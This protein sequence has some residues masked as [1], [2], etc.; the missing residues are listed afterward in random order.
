MGSAQTH[1]EAGAAAL[2][3]GDLAAAQTAFEATVERDSAH[4]EGWHQLGLVHFRAHRLEEAVYGIERSLAEGAADARVH[5]NLGTVLQHLGRLDEAL[6]RYSEALE[7]DPDH[8]SA[9]SNLAAILTSRFAHEEA[10]AHLR[11]VLRL[12]PNHG[13]AWNNLGVLCRDTLRLEEALE[14]FDHAIAESTDSL[15]AHSNRLLTLNYLPSITAKEIFDAHKAFGESVDGELRSMSIREAD[16]SPIRVGYVSGDLRRHSVAFFIEPVLAAHDRSRFHVTCYSNAER[17]DAVT[18]TLRGLSDAWRDISMLSNEAARALIEQD[19]ID[20]LVDLSGHS[21]R[22]RL[23]L[24]ADRAAPVQVT[25]L[26]YP[27]TTGLK[28]MDYRLTDE[29]ADPDEADALHTERLIRLPGGFHCYRPPVG[30]PGVESLPASGGEPFTFGSFNNLLKVT[31][32]VLACWAA[33]LR[34]VP[35]SRLLLKAYQLE[36]SGARDHV[37]SVLRAQGIDEDRVLLEGWAA[38]FDDHLAQ[39]H[40]VDVALDP[41]PYNGTTTTLEALWMGVPTITL[42]CDRHA[43][44]VGASLMTHVGLKGFIA[45]SIER[46]VALAAFLASDL[47][48]LGRLRKSM[49]QALLASG[50]CDGARFTRELERVYDAFVGRQPAPRR[51]THLLVD[52]VKVVTPSGHHLLTPFVL[53]EQQDWFEDEIRF[54]RH[55]AL[56]GATVLDIGANYGTFALSLA[57]AVGPEGRVIAVEPTP[58]TASCLRESIAANEAEHLELL[59]I[60]LSDQEGILHLRLE[61][62]SELNALTET[63]S[64]DGTTVEVQSLTLDKVME[65]RGWPKLDLVKLDAEGAEVRILAGSEE[66]LRRSSPLI[67][68]EIK[69]GATLNLELADSFTDREFDLY[70]L[71]PGLNILEPYDPDATLD[72]FQLNLFACREDTAVGL[73]ERG[74]LVRRHETLAERSGA[75]VLTAWLGSLPYTSVL[76]PRWRGAGRRPGA[77][78]YLSALE[79]YSAA[80]RDPSCTAPQRLAALDAAI[81]LTQEAVERSSTAARLHSLARMLRDRGRRLASVEQL[82]VL[83]K[84]VSAGTVELDE[85]FFVADPEFEGISPGGELGLWCLAAAVTARIRSA[86]FSSYFSRDTTRPALEQ[87]SRMGF[88]SPSFQRRLELLT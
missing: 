37:R 30:S 84:E 68:F 22:N 19:K 46:Y 82:V 29:I 3:R 66:T 76:A 9:H 47:E 17:Q 53:A 58:D 87:L 16:G 38:G 1:F 15:V 24:F 26:G 10:E 5:A 65:P 13:N 75:E 39:Y 56:P 12:R 36:S 33:V 11:H 48:R 44:R 2:Q 14:A 21:A 42:A 59:E 86:S 25:W 57:K 51:S 50:L 88:L 73:E 41:F 35:G 8:V 18:K 60:A 79:H 78:E 55:W 62:D 85:P 64:E 81:R 27:N 72:A 7:R 63:A 71:V 69:H 83:V 67:L 70:L 28:T 74:L 49:R 6:V 77:L 40:R 54:L 20:I 52:G 31:D 23:T 4:H 34:A 43:G 61:D 45:D 32:D 80:C